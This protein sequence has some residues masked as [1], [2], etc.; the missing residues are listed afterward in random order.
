MISE[1]LKFQTKGHIHNAEG[2]IT[3]PGQCSTHHSGSLNMDLKQVHGKLK[4]AKAFNTSFMTQPL[5]VKS[6]LGHFWQ[7][8]IQLALYSKPLLGT[9][10]KQEM[11]VTLKMMLHVLRDPP[12]SLCQKIRR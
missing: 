8:S 11:T 6:P 3:E 5:D 12:A 1:T 4:S 2:L 9:A 7:P 10:V